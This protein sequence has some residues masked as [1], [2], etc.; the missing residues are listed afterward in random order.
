MNHTGD[1]AID[2]NRDVF[3][4]RPAARAGLIDVYIWDRHFKPL[5]IDNVSAHEDD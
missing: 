4:A 3:A 5:V 2:G 1:G